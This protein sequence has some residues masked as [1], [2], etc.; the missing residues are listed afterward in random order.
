MDE[1]FQPERSLL[2][3]DLVSKLHFQPAFPLRVGQTSICF[4]LWS[5]SSHNNTCSVQECVRS[6]C[7]PAV[8]FSL[9]SHGLRACLMD[10]SN[11]PWNIT[12][13]LQADELWCVSKKK[14][15]GTM[16]SIFCLARV[17]SESH[18]LLCIRALRSQS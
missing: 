9:G 1:G 15:K 14:K 8:P 13:L 17:H 10:L 11:R 4:E 2:P 16:K 12:T 18:F 6:P 7:N 5:V 3:F